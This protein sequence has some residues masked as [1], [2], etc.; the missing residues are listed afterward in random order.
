MMS[1]TRSC[2]NPMMS[3]TFLETG[4]LM[5]TKK[6][7]KIHLQAMKMQNLPMKTMKTILLLRNG[8]EIRIL[9]QHWY[10][11]LIFNA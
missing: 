10:Y 11:F 7:P 1:L 2:S 3:L 4:L 8:G 9:I 5:M 6:I